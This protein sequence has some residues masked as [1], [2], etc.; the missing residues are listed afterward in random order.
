VPQPPS[1]AHLR[2]LGNFGPPERRIAVV[3][4]G[5]QLHNVRQ[6]AVIE[7]QFIVQEIGYESL[8]IGFV[9]FPDAPPQR[10][11]AGGAG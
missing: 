9:G 5:D 4:S 2:Y 3:L 7:G 11:P 10:L 8:A 6:G 1:A